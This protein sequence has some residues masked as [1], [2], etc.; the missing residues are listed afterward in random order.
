MLEQIHTILMEDHLKDAQQVKL[1]TRGLIISGI[2]VKLKKV[3]F[4]R[5]ILELDLTL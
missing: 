3:I 5:I 2:R 1:T 4:G